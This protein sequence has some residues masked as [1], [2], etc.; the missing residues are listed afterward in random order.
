MIT[1]KVI[2]YIPSDRAHLVEDDNGRKRR[3]DLIVDGGF[4]EDTCP[5]SLVGKTFTSVSEFPFIAIAVG[6]E[7]LKEEK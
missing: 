1:Y 7:E 6:V 5:E 4:P 2:K 3:V